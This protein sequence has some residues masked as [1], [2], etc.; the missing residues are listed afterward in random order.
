MDRI[1][2]YLNGEK[3][4]FALK[5]VQHA[6]HN[7]EAVVFPASSKRGEEIASL[8]TTLGCKHLA[9]ADV[10]SPEFIEIVEKMQPRLSIV[11]GYSTIFKKS[12]INLPEFGTI[13]LHGG[14]VPEYR[15]GS[16]LNW[17]IINGEGEIG[18]SV[19]R[20]DERIDAGPVLAEGTIQFKLED[21]IASI[22]KKAN[23]LFPKLLVEAL[24]AIDSNTTNFR[25]Q[26][27]KHAKY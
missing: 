19:L 24:G 16:P 8:A 21:D 26:D 3:G 25:K 17:Q 18:I 11:G 20:M 7:V 27:E 5:A 12:L 6:G 14:R 23:D 4:I 2:F 13:N 1:V 9:I 22:H 15:G 10:N